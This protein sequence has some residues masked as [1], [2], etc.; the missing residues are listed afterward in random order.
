LNLNFYAY[1]G[2]RLEYT[3]ELDDLT[4]NCRDIWLDYC[5]MDG[6]SG[7]YFIVGY[8][9]WDS[10][11]ARYAYSGSD[12]YTEISDLSLLEQEKQKILDIFK[13]EVPILLPHITK[14]W[15]LIFVPH[16]H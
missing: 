8:L 3:K 4:E 11:D 2:I 6:M 13:Q 16:Y 7:E 14:P 5:L 12:G 9:L 15:S 1:F 10:G